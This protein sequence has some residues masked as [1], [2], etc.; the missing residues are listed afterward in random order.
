MTFSVQHAIILV[1]ALACAAYAAGRVRAV[2]S[3]RLANGHL[4]SLPGY[5]GWYAALWTLIPAIVAGLVG[6]FVSLPGGLIMVLLP[7]LAGLGGAYALSRIR[8]DQTAQAHTE[9][10]VRALLWASGLTAILITIGII[11]S[12]AFETVS[13]FASPGVSLLEFF[14]GLEWS[15]QTASAFGAVPLFFG[16]FFIA[17]LALLFA[18]PIGLFSA[19][20]LSE[21][22]SPRMRRIVKPM[23]EMLAGVPTVVYG[24]FAILVVSPAVDGLGVAIN[25]LFH[26]LTGGEDI[27]ATQP[28]NALSAGLVMGIMIV[29]I[30]SSLSDDV[31]CAVP[32][33]LRN[34]AL[35]LGATRSEM[36]KHVV[37]P[38]AFPGIMAAFL[39]A[40]SRA[41]GETMIVVMAAGERANLTLNPF[42]DVTTVTVQ[43]VSLL[44]GDPEFDSPRT[45]SAFALGAML[46]AITLLCNA[47]AQWVVYRQRKRYAGL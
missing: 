33:K 6:W 43:I 46:F 1:L 24:F 18:A 40:V 10:L 17:F 31:M 28:R 39:L 29:P 34:A 21:Y 42:E 38:A 19:I 44:S 35:S 23:L 30:I 37:L 12:L 45:L 26:P 16:T 20:Y 7:V 22:A 3:A 47:L 15:A 13:F 41:I 27:L 5:Y 4:A 36:L 8:H 9:R 25:Q 2:Q 32:T 11:L 14:T